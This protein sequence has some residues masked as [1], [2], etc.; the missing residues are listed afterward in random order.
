MEV[1][2]MLMKRGEWILMWLV[3]CTFA[4]VVSSQPAVAADRASLGINLAGPADWNTELPFVDVFRMARTW[5]SQREDSPWG[6]GPEL[7]LDPQGWVTQLEPGC[8]AE[9][10]LCTI[11]GGRFPQGRY[12][13][14]YDGQGK[15][16]F[17][18]AR[19]VEE[20]PGRMVIEPQGNGGFFLQIR[21]ID[22]TDPIRNL[23]VI[24]PGF[25]SSYREQIFRPGFLEMWRGMASIRFMDW[26]HT[27]NSH[28]QRWEDRPKL[29]N[30]SWSRGIPLEVM[31]DL[32]NRLKADPWFCIPHLAD[33]D[34]VRRFAST[35][36]QQLDPDLKVYVEYSNEVWNG[37]FA[38]SK[39]A[40]EQG[41]QLRFSDKPW[42]AA[43]RYT[44]HRSVQIFSIFEDVFGG[45][46][47][48][49][50][51][52]PSQA[53]NAHVGREVVNWQDAH[54]HADALAIAPYVSMNISMQG[55]KTLPGAETVAS[56]SV[57]QV[58]DYLEQTALPESIRWIRENKDVADSR[59]LKLIAYEAGQH[60]VG[61]QGAE[62]VDRLT[63]LLHAANRH[64]RMGSI[65][66]K[67]LDAWRA[68]GGGLMAIFSSVSR[69]NKWGSWGLLEYYDQ[70]V[71][72]VAK[73]R[74]VLESSTS[75]S[76]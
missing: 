73:A 30:F 64:E 57:D 36:K 9:T 75:G 23:R 31:I 19:I 52:L 20:R 72:E 76:R 58:L 26:M 7:T 67:Y 10:P 71:D 43:W 6:Q 5:I 55:G 60:A 15:I 1:D 38:Q 18:G 24:M 50:R 16:A 29:D 45:K 51:V 63:E 46:D 41:R 33:D 8:W 25:E 62:N 28:V 27:N 39:Y 65:Y 12:V 49:V 2:E 35:V 40:G 47:R 44:A 14:L 4:S 3:A 59:G 56:W 61:I 22:A 54:Q 21:Q 42:E 74:V 17:N 66:G 37:Q 69:W 13:V 11:E 70:P 68:E 34:Y 48:L 32:S 53:A